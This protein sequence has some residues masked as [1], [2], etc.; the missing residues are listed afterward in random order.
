MLA[1]RSYD[2]ALVNGVV[3]TV[4][5]C[6]PGQLLCPIGGKAVPYTDTMIIR[7]FK[8]M[9]NGLDAAILKVVYT[10]WKNAKLVKGRSLAVDIVRNGEIQAIDNALDELDGGLPRA[11]NPEKKLYQD[12]WE[13]FKASTFASFYKSVWAYGG[14][15]R[16]FAGIAVGAA[17]AALVAT[18]IIASVLKVEAAQ[19]AAIAIRSIALLIATHCMIVAIAGYV[20]IAKSAMEGVWNALKADMG[21]I[22]NINRANGAATA[23]AVVMTWAAFG[24]LC[25]VNRLKPGGQLGLCWRGGLRHRLDGGHDHP[26]RRLRRPRRHRGHR[27]GHL[28]HDQ[29]HRQPDLQRPPREGAKAARLPTGCAAASP[30]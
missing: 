27:P 3:N 10:A 12:L 29:C 7:A 9:M 30:V 18:I 1:A 21:L 20:K 17:A 24:V 26:V 15:P 13:K 25:A 6:V 11:G 2:M 5:H 8:D 19:V 28:W 14:A 22:R 16:V 23:L 4:V